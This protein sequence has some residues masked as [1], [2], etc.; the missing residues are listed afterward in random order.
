MSKVGR[1]DPCPCNSGRKWKACC[2]DRAQCDACGVSLPRR[3][4]EPQ[5]GLWIRGHLAQA[6]A[7]C[8]AAAQEEAA[9]RTGA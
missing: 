8:K 3:Q 4:L 6:C 2:M 5:P 1:N 9:C 7:A